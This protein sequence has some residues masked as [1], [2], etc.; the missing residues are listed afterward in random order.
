MKKNQV[1]NSI[2]IFGLATVSLL[3][4]GFSKVMT[5]PPTL[6]VPPLSQLLPKILEASFETSHYDEKRKE[7][8]TGSEDILLPFDERLLALAKQCRLLKK[9]PSNAPSSPSEWRISVS[10][11]DKTI[12]GRGR[13]LVNIHYYPKHHLLCLYYSDVN[14]KS[15]IPIATLKR[16]EPDCWAK[17]SPELD[18]YLQKAIAKHQKK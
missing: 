12:Y 4:Y 14:V 5:A 7:F 13:T 2:M 17:S 10:F 18:D 16:R 9:T 3:S 1:R 11:E 6:P 8:V 15:G